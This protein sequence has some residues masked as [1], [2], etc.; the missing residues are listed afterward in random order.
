MEIDLSFSQ[1]LSQFDHLN[2]LALIFSGR[3]FSGSL[4]AGIGIYYYRIKKFKIFL[5][6]CLATGFGDLLGN[7]LKDLFL[8]PRPCYSYIDLFPNTDRCGSDLTGMP[9][10]H[11]LNFFIFSTLVHLNLKKPIISVI[12]FASSLLVALSRVL[13]VKHLLSQ[14]II[15]ALIG[16]IMG[17][18]F[19][20]ALQKWIKI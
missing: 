6:I 16:I 4:I 20:T 3:V 8:Q 11:A 17:I 1:W 19:N 12:F 14:V 7:F 18:I 9:S 5:F 10:N 2:D 13:L 15:G